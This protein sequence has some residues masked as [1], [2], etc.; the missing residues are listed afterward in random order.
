M[1]H[2][3]NPS[4]RRSKSEKWAENEKHKSLRALI[5]FIFHTNVDWANSKSLA[6]VI[7]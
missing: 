5:Y 4:T 7:L 2:T 3:K 6:G 1:C